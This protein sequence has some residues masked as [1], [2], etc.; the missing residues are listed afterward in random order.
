MMSFKGEATGCTSAD[1]GVDES[2][3]AGFQVPV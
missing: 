1:N 2:K 3:E